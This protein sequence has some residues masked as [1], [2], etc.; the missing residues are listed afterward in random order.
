MVESKRD[1]ADHRGKDPATRAPDRRSRRRWVPAV[2]GWLCLLTGLTD[3][4]GA[5]AP[6]WHERMLK[7]TD[8]IPGAFTNAARTATVITGL[9]L[10]LLSH[11]LRRRKRRAWQ[12]VVVLLALS[13][14]FHVVKNLAFGEAVVTAFM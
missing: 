11:A 3:V 8:I 5:I 7:L 4:L 6:E 9:L 13:I 1:T 12:A 14:V 10:L 2:A